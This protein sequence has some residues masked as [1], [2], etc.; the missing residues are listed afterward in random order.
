MADSPRFESNFS[1]DSEAVLEVEP[2]R[3]NSISKTGNFF[4]NLGILNKFELFGK[5]KM[6]KISKFRY[7]HLRHV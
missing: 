7:T 2:R 4:G 5:V 3:P 1:S 6:L